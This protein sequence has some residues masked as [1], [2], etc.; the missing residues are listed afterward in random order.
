M[1]KIKIY[2][3]PTEHEAK[4]RDFESVKEEG[5]MPQIDD[6]AMVWESLV[7][8]GLVESTEAQLD[9]VFRCLNFNHPQD[10]KGHS[11]SV[12]D[13]VEMDGK[14][15]YCDDMGW[16]ELPAPAMKNEAFIV[17][18]SGSSYYKEIYKTKEEADAR[19]EELNE[20]YYQHKVWNVEKIEVK[21]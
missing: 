1:K 4:F 17:I 5:I 11:L 12:S 16:E 21:F 8:F 15:Y 9:V 10:F 14:F 20:D 7:D 13:V 3:L 19:A 18:S 6:Y 2:Q